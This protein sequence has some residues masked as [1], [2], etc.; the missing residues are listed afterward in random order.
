MI[1]AFLLSEVAASVARGGGRGKA[2]RA[3]GWGAHDHLWVRCPDWHWTAPG[4]RVRAV[5]RRRLPGLAF[6]NVQR[7]ALLSA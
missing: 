7:F 6:A 2:S 1:A 5:Q 3:A 4:L